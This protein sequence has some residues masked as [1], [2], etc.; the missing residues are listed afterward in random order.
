VSIIISETVDAADYYDGF[1][2]GELVIGIRAYQ[3]GWEYF[4]PKNIDLNYNLKTSYSTFVG[5]SI[6]YNNTSSSTLDSNVLWKYYQKKSNTNQINTPADL[7]LSPNDKNSNLSTVNFYNVGS[8]ISSDSDAFKKIQKFSKLSS[9][10][11]SADMLNNSSK[12]KKIHNL[13]ISGSYVENNTANYGTQRQHNF[14]SLDSTLP[15]FSTLVDKRSFNKFFDYTTSVATNDQQDKVIAKVL[16]FKT[17]HNSNI[18]PAPSIN[19]GVLSTFGALGSLYNYQDVNFT[20]WLFENNNNYN[21]NS[22]TDGKSDSNP[23]LSLTRLNANKKILKS[24]DYNLLSINDLGTSTN[25][26]FF[27]WNLFNES[28]NY[29]FKDLKSTN[30]GFLSPDKNTRYTANNSASYAY[31]DLTYGTSSGQ[32]LNNN[33]SL[34]NNLHKNYSVSLND[35][36]SSSYISKLLTTNLTLTPNHNPIYSNNPT[37]DTVYVDKADKNLGTETPNIFRGK[38]E[39]AP[40]YIFNTYWKS[41]W[42]NINLKHNY[43][44]ILK[45]ITMLEKAYIPQIHEYSE[46]DFKN[47]QALES[48]EDAM[49]ESTHSSFSQ[50]DYMLIKKNLSGGSSFDKIQDFYNNDARKVNKTRF[51]FRNAYKPVGLGVPNSLMLYTTEYF[52]N[53]SFSNLLNFNYYNNDSL[54]E[55]IDDSYENIKNYKYIYYNLHQNLISNSLNFLSP[56]SYSSVLDS[57][58]ADFDENDWDV[59]WENSQ[60]GYNS[61]T[62]NK[63]MLPGLT[64]SIKLRS[65]AKNSIVTYSAIQKVFKSR[66]DESRSNTNFKDVTNSFTSYPFLTEAKSPYENMLGKNKE[67]FFNINLY[68][69]SMK[70]NLSLYL[71]VWNSL[72][73]IFIDIPFLLSMKSDASRYFWFDWQ[74]RWSSIEVQPSSIAKYSLAGLPYFTKT[75][76][77]STQLGDELNDSENYLT[78]LSRARKNYMPN[79]SCSPYFYSKVNNWFNFQHSLYFFDKPDTKLTKFLLNH[80]SSYWEKNNINSSD[81]ILS[82]PSFSSMNTGNKVTWSPLSGIAGQYYSTSVLI[83]ILSKREQLYRSYFKHNSKILALPKSLTASPNNTLL[84]E[85]SSCYSFIDPST[86]SSEITREFLYENAHFLNYSILKDFVKLSNSLS[87]QLPLNFSLISNYFTHLLGYSDNYTGVGKNVDLYKSQYR[88]M[89]KGITSMIRL[90]ATS[91]IAMPTEIRIHILASSKDVIHSWAIPSA[92]IKIDC[93]PGYSSHRVAIFLTHGIFWGQCMEICGRYHH[94]MPIVVYFMK[95]DLFFLWC[96]HFMH[97]S[98]LESSFAMG[99]KQLTDY[100]RLVSFSKTTWVNELNNNML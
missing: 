16:P 76:E 53:P 27:T 18:E 44:N 55:N 6:K 65:T 9:N 46:Y 77:Y 8:N 10:S 3:W 70:N 35:W 17:I 5:N 4:Y 22:T 36:G 82:T 78:K 49:W 83:D 15:A 54:V 24:G 98:D 41:Y 96:T 99:D 93:V 86:Y 71:N 12:F 69:K 90:Q 62:T 42:Q 57:F 60:D 100:L 21:L 37:W 84:R 66:F 7:I 2:T 87:L 80:A 51:K 50:E 33:I 97:Y 56:V 28:K 85:I 67:S 26:S 79:W 89:K 13:Y 11:V 34:G 20:K 94:W 14:S 61:R 74:S 63:N 47:W 29:R 39:L 38:E 1:G 68:S 25:S 81:K 92:G 64:N 91:A 30:L 88:P 59:N 75:F 52:T 45:N 72:N 48:L 23:P 73:T 58:R 40:D 95:R 19:P 31:S 32:V 43:T